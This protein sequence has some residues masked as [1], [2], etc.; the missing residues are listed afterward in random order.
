MSSQ[1]FQ[2]IDALSVGELIDYEDYLDLS[3]DFLPEFTSQS[4][5]STVSRPTPSIHIS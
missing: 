1:S 5:D 2:I 3:L 4:S